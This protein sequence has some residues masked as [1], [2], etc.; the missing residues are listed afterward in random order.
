[1]TIRFVVR[2]AI[3]AALG[4]CTRA[5]AHAQ[6]IADYDYEN[7]SFRG[8]GFDLGRIWP[9][10]VQST[11]TYTVRLDFGFL[12]PDVRVVPSISYWSS[13][14]KPRELERLATQ[15]NRLPSLQDRGI[16]VTAAELGKIDW[17]ALSLSMDAQFVFT[18]PWNVFTYVGAGVGLYALN[19]KGTVISNTLWEDLLDS[20][21]AGGALMAGAEVPFSKNFRLYGELRYTLL[22]DVR[23]P[24]FRVGGAFMLPSSQ[25]GGATGAK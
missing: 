25:T 4:L 23:Y 22:T 21:S 8:I 2:T 10:K 18:I 12:G 5:S 3:V 6:S 1:M 14:F 24:G 15:L 13:T 20:V 11:E 19:G 9:N 16:T 7:L 17:S